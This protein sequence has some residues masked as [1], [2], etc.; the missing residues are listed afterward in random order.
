M[1]VV[2][3]IRAFLGG[4]TH[5]EAELDA[6][7]L[8][9]FGYQFE[10]IPPYR[11][12]CERAARTPGAVASWR[13]IPMVP[14]SA[15]ATVELATEAPR[16]TFRSSGTLG[17]AR[18]VHRHPFPDLYRAAV[19]AT[20]PRFCLGAAERPPMLALVPPRAV[21][22]D[23]SLGFMVDHVLA[24]FG[25][26]GSGYGFGARGVEIGPCRSWLAAR[27]R[28]GEPVL[29][30][31]SAFALADLLAFL[32]RSN[33]HFRLPAGSAIFETGGFK[34]RAK[35]LSRAELLG[36][37]AD[38]LGVPSGR[39]VSEYGMTELTSQAYTATL[40]GGDPEL[41][42][43]APWMRVRALDPATLAELPAGE[44]G[45][46]AIFDLANVGSALHVLTEDLGR[47]EPGGF[48]LAGRAPDADL[49]GCSLLAE[50]LAR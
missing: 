19:D 50:E 2:E 27:Q 14:A 48:R 21:A 4:A 45:L 25:G 9:A 29:V 22:P 46:L 35:T 16:E 15:F 49:R 6:L 11:A 41:F 8:A 47:T 33:L 44:T 23:S 13:E 32:A 28:G 10:R 43:P 17:S 5:A 42:V 3:R 20:F 31:A 24:R 1:D 26:P 12:L 37:A 39:V 36:A 40:A 18:S 34:G 38:W 30:L 7:A